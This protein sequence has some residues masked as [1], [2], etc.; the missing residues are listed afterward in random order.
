MDKGT[1]AAI[2]SLWQQLSGFVLTQSIHT[3]A[4]L[5]IADALAEG[6]LAPAEIASRVR[7][8][9]DAVRRVLRL[10]AGNGVFS[11]TADGGFENTA[12]S[13]L[14]RAGVPGSQREAALHFGT[15]MYAAAGGLPAAVRRGETAFDA[16]F[17]EPFFDYLR[18]HPE[19]AANFD[20]AMSSSL[21]ARIAFV[22]LYGW[23]GFTRVVDVGGGTGE[24]MAA[25]LRRTPGLTGAVVDRPE[26]EAQARQAFEEAGVADRAEFIG[27]D[28]FESVP[29]GADAYLLSTVLHDWDDRHAL[30][31][32]R[33]C[34]VAMP[35]G[36]RLVIVDAVLEPGNAPSFTRVMDVLMLTVVSGRERTEPEWRALLESGGFELARV[37]ASPLLA[38]LEA[39]PV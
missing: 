24:L 16:A 22:L 5:G 13:T 39:V 18:H 31:I 20:A 25:I 17:G 4:E 6:P 27:G 23:S 3:A 28:F 19:S 21:P 34:R 8:D 35:P 33:N 2:A 38:I 15:L 14:L 32:L 12:A 37:V 11:E 26:L 9:A 1:A 36:G 10:L 29:E 7:A 30:G